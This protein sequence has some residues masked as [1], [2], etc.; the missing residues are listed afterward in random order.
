MKYEPGQQIVVPYPFVRDTY[1]RSDFDEDGWT[2][3]PTP[4]WKPG[5]R[6]EQVPPEGDTVTHVD[7]IGHMILTVVSL[8]KPGTFPTRVFFLRTWRNPEGVEF[9]KR[10]LRNTTQSAF[11]AMAR[12]YR[13]WLEVDY[14][15]GKRVHIYEPEDVA[16]LCS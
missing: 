15:A 10:K 4:T 3:T 16:E 11:T 8:H 2:T 13:Y 14:V 6:F 12:G 1:E 9:G 7:A 5:S